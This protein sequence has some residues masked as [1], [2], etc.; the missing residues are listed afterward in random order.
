MIL[1]VYP[2]TF[3]DAAPRP[4]MQ[5]FFYPA[6][7]F[8]VLAARA[9]SRQPGPGASC[10]GVRAKTRWAE[11]RSAASETCMENRFVQLS[12]SGKPS[13]FLPVGKYPQ[14]SASTP[15]VLAV[16]RIAAVENLPRRIEAG[17]TRFE[18]PGSGASVYSSCTGEE[19]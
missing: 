7:R 1:P 17:H 16:H 9:K 13:P 12:Q 19:Q 4:A 18:N 14:D 5:D 15:Q 3:M 6:R 10:P 11:A 2:F 8:V